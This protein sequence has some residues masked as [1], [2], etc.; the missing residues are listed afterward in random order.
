MLPAAWFVRFDPA[1]RRPRSPAARAAASRRR[2]SWRLLAGELRILARTAPRWW[3]LAA[4][5]LNAAALAVPATVVRPAGASTALLL[6][7]AWIWPVLVWSRLGT[8]RHENGLDTL[9]GAYPGAG[10]QLTAEWLAGVLV[11]AAAG[12]GPL[13]AMIAAGDGPRTAAWA[14]AVAFIP[15]LALLLGTVT[16]THRTFQALYLILWYAAVNQVAAA[17][18]MGTVLVHGRPAG[19][20]ALLTAGVALVM[21]AVAVTVRTARHATR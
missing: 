10:R 16:R 17:D 9:L 6:S 5:G 2:G 18:Y 21:V 12:V 14:A 11:T 20:S 7:A 13:L 3:W 19:P 1:R 4:A 15:S 8:Q